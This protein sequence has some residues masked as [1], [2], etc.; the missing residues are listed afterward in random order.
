MK[1][2]STYLS[3]SVGLLNPKEPKIISSTSSVHNALEYLKQDSGG[4]VLVCDEQMK[5]IG[6]FTER[7]VLKKIAGKVIAE[8]SQIEL[9]MTREPV[10]I[11]MTSPLAYALQLMSEGGFRHLPI[12]DD[13]Q[14]AIGII[15]MK[16]IV[17][18][19]VRQFVKS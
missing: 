11:Q 16:D 1:I 17:D 5:V 14:T 18:E 9:F 7:D 10:S 12:V 6:I 19:I 4:A 2:D 3:R 8:N 15:S 13:E